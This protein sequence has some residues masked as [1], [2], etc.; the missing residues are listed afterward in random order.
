MSSNSDI[1][2]EINEIQIL[3]QQV[4]TFK[5]R[6][7]EKFK[8]TTQSLGGQT[9]LA[10]TAKDSVASDERSVP[11]INPRDSKVLAPIKPLVGNWNLDS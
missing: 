2:R 9:S 3:N 4:K 5:A 11:A 10:K 1:S 7:D 6:C 8:A